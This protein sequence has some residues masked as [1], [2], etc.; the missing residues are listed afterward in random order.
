MK[1]FKL[2]K[3]RRR[4]QGHRRRVTRRKQLKGG[5]ADAEMCA[6]T[7]IN[8]LLMGNFNVGNPNKLQEGVDDYAKGIKKEAGVVGNV[9]SGNWFEGPGP[10]PAFPTC[11]IM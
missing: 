6:N 8:K 5:A 10:P 4:K 7:D 1:Q 2:A 9:A 3:T 11:A